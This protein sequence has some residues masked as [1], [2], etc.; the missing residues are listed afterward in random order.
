MPTRLKRLVC[1]SFVLVLACAHSD[2]VF[3]STGG[4]LPW[5]SP[6]ST[7]VNFITGPFV[8]YGLAGI[9]VLLGLGFAF[10]EERMNKWL[11]KGARL[12]VGGFAAATAITWGI[13]FF[14]AGYGA[15]LP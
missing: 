10:D 13:P 11:G 9:I 6:M 1:S 2:S 5:D 14:G 3:A 8:R 15:L 12:I 7:M 4:S